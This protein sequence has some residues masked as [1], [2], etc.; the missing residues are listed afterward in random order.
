M[1][2]D[3]NAEFLALMNEEEQHS[4]WPAAKPIPAG[5]VEK[6]RGTRTACLE[7]IEK[8]WTDMRPLSLRKEMDSQKS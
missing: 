2:D 8:S 3:E 1:F 5:W 6:S 4:L 7:Y